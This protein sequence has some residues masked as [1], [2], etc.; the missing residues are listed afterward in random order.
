M[1]DLAKD[2]FANVALFIRIVAAGWVSY[3]LLLLLDSNE[4]LKLFAALKTEPGIYLA[5][6]AAGL[7]GACTYALYM[8]LLEIFF[9]FFVIAW[10][11]KWPCTP[12]PT[13]L[14]TLSVGN[15]LQRMYAE[16]K[17]R[18]AATDL[19]VK[20]VQTRL[21]TFYAWLVFLYCTATLVAISAGVAWYYQLPNHATEKI[22]V[23][24]AITWLIAFRADV[25]ITQLEMWLLIKHPQF[26]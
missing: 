21:D 17:A 6:T 18:Y 23:V 26:P 2:A 15:L 1:N 22:A 14:R 8:G 10:V 11:R 24:A 19:R 4:Q 3:A 5:L 9:L 20:E 7:C 25:F 16:R 13:T 12:L